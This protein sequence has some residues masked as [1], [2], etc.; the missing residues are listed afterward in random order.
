MGTALV[1]LIYIAGLASMVYFYRTLGLDFAYHP[2]NR[3]KKKE[4][5]L[6]LCSSLFVGFFLC[7]LTFW[8]C[9]FPIFTF[10]LYYWFGLGAAIFFM[11]MC[12]LL[13][14]NWGKKQEEIADWRRS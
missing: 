2:G 6:C 7:G 5:V 13:T 14:L 9:G 11:G 4:G 3:Y 8:L 12:Y 1:I 10:E